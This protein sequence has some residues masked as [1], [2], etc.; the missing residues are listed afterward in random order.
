MIKGIDNGILLNRFSG[1]SPGPS[2][3]VSGVAKNSFLIENGAVAGALKETMVSFNII[4]VLGK[5]DISK[6]RCCNGY[7]ILPW[8]CFDG[9]TISGAG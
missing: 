9:I 7:S 3:D 6:E 8:C 4:D 2:G 1:A 5:I